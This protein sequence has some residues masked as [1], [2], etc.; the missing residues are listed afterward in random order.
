MSHDDPQKQTPIP[1][2]L[3][4]YSRQIRL[5]AIDV[6]GQQRLSESSALVVGCG[7]LGSVISESLVRAGVGLVRLVDRD[8]LELHN[9]QRQVLYDEH[10][11]ASGL[12][13]AIAAKTK[14]QAING[15]V[16]IEAFVE[17]LNYKNI[18]T[19]A[20]D[21]FVI[22]DGTDN[23]ETRFLIN[24]YAL[25][26]SVPW[27]YGGC[28]GSE[29]QSMTIL[30]GQTSCL[31]CLMTDGPPPPGTTPGCDIAGVVGPIVNVIASIQSMEALKI[32]SGNLPAV[33]RHLTV[34]D[35]WSGRFSRMEL[36]DLGQR[37]N[38][39]ACVQGQRVWLNGQRASQSTVLCGRNSVQIRS[40]SDT[41]IDLAQLANR[42]QDHGEVTVNEFLLKFQLPDY[43]LTVFANGRAIISGTGDPTKAKSLYT[44]WIGS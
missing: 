42:L 30:P 34:V 35:L 20:Q 14:L 31:H 37:V 2:E 43:Q 19:L 32:L 8:F 29:G 27:I 10:D 33:N 16:Q 44:Q 39:P 24:D 4:R 12:P 3:E 41:Q 18:A 11:V 17:D 23:F 6:Q 25:E 26:N 21:V 13:K 36:E 15:R 40:S 28:L 22:V 1:P 5:P 7:A 9:L 38:C